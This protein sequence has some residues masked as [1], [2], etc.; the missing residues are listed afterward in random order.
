MNK[1][2]AFILTG[3]NA[4]NKTKAERA[5]LKQHMQHMVS[6]FFFRKTL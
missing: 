6:G 1:K 2:Q 5:K 4:T 3:T